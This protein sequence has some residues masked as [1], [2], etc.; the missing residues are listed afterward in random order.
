MAAGSSGIPDAQSAGP[1]PV[2]CGVEDP[3]VGAGSDLIQQR[4]E[5]RQGTERV[6]HHEHH[7]RKDVVDQQKVVP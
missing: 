5:W 4:D 2:T 6:L 7:P 3:L 1:H